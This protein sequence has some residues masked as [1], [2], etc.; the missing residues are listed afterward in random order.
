MYLR[1]KV[2]PRVGLPNRVEMSS[3]FS[4]EYEPY[5]FDLPKGGGAPALGYQLHWS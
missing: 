3:R 5:I 2:N 4:S 1:N